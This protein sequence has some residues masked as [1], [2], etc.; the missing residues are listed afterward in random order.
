MWHVDLEE[1]APRLSDVAGFRIFGG[2]PLTR[3]VFP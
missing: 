2:S 1:E 3:A